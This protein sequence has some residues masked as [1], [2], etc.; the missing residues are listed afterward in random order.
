MAI[1]LSTCGVVMMIF[2]SKVPSFVTLS[3]E[4]IAYSFVEAF[5]L[6]AVTI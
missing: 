6:L 3:S 5:T 4:Y 1:C 2:L